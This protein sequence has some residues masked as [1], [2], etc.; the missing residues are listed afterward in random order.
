MGIAPGL[1]LCFANADDFHRRALEAAETMDASAEWFLLNAEAIVELD[2]T[3]ADAL[4]GLRDQLGE[5]GVEFA[6]AHV[7]QELREELDAAGLV[8]RIGE[9]R[10]FATLPA[11]VAAYARWY[12]RRHGHLPAGMTPPVVPPSPMTRTS[13]SDL[14][15]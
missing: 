7:K 10:I 13:E 8:A 4:G 11:A 1:P 6:L 5:R 12:V 3:G 9:D 14:A 15:E 2:I